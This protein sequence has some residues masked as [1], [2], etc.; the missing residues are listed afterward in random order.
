MR[1][2][3]LTNFYPP[4]VRSIS[5]MMRELA[6]GLVERGHE[7]TVLTSWPKENVSPDAP[8]DDLREDMLEGKVRV[9]RVKVPSSY[10]TRYWLR[11]LA[12]LIMPYFFWRAVRR[13]QYK[14]IEGVIVY[15]PHLPLTLV[16]ERVKRIYSARYLLN[17][18]D[19][20][21]QNAIDLGIMHNR[22]LIRF[23]ERMEA[24]AYRSVDAITTHTEGGRRFLIEKKGVPADK[25]RTMYNWIDV[26]AFASPSLQPSSTRGEGDVRPFRKQY[27]LE[28][29]FLFLFAGIFGPSQGLELIVE[30]AHRVADLEAVHFLMVGEGT[31]K[32]RL[33]KLAASFHLSNMSFQP[34]VPPREYPA[35][36]KEVDVGLMCLAPYNTTAVVPGKLTGYMAAGLPVVGFLQ[37]QSEGHRIVQESGCGYTVV[38]DN[39]QEVKA[40]VR[41]IWSERA[42]LKEYGQRGRDYSVRN[43]SRRHC[44]DQLT[45]IITGY[46]ML[47]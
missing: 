12:Q 19:I 26:D 35:L 20:F 47:Y 45:Q 1:I 7:V 15:T 2:L 23:F 3:L 18:Q 24:R 29:K 44:I 37:K 16:G 46:K 32:E 11:G 17:V 4:E 8:L 28:G 25:V 34:F 30:T 27:G 39:P 6:E 43:F 31:E 40:V 13:L 33:Q 21:P 14:T 5:T 41:K 9:M 10:S 38:S 36:L 42:R 22:L